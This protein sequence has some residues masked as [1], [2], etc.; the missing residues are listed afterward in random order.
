MT[1]PAGDK[2][3]RSTGMAEETHQEA[4]DPGRD[5]SQS[6]EDVHE[7]FL[8]AHL[9]AEPLVFRLP[10][11]LAQFPQHVPIAGTDRRLEV[12]ES[13]ALLVV[14]TQGSLEGVQA[15]GTDQ[16]FVLRRHRRSLRW[17][18]EAIAARE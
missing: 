7:H 1:G 6:E 8:P 9:P 10:F 2:L 14:G 16:G 12:A 3:G 5:Q 18:R 15:L 11:V 17:S 13:R 4:L